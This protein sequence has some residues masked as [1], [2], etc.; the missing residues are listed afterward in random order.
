MRRKIDYNIDDKEP[1]TVAKVEY[2][3]K[4]ASLRELNIFYDSNKII[5]L[6]CKALLKHMK[7]DKK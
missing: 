6:L 1:L 5:I 2:W 3:L 4:K 7:K